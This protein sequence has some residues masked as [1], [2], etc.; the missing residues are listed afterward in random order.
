MKHAPVSSSSSC[1]AC[2]RY[3]NAFWSGSTAFEMR[4]TLSIGMPVPQSLVMS[5]PCRVGD[6]DDVMA[7]EPLL[8]EPVGQLAP[9]G[10]A[11]TCT[12]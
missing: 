8:D 5:R 10:L 11:S 6:D 12:R 3:L 2:S 7:A 4:S 9:A 1:Q